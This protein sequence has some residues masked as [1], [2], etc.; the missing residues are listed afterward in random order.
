MYV[1]V[2]EKEYLSVALFLFHNSRIKF[3]RNNGKLN[4]TRYYSSDFPGRA[5]GI[6]YARSV[7]E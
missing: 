1:T 4:I 5:G 2:S 6:V 3:I 7:V